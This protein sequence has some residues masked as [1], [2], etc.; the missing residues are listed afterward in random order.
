MVRGVSV[1]VTAALLLLAGTAG[2][3][4]IVFSNG[5]PNPNL[6]IVNGLDIQ[7]TGASSDDFLLAG[8]TLIDGVGFYFQNYYGID[9]WNLDINYSIFDDAGDVPGLLLDSGIGQNVVATDTGQPWYAFGN[10]FEVTFD[11]QNPFTATGGSRYWLQLGGATTDPAFPDLPPPNAFWVTAPDNGSPTLYPGLDFQ[12][13]PQPTE[14]QLAFNLTGTSIADVPE[15]ASLTLV[16][17][18]LL[19][20]ARRWRQKRRKNAP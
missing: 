18:G 14:N 1:V 11:L 5:G 9:G 7:G 6:D 3:S 19:L 17:L 10:V 12:A 15:P 2:A 16:G 13:D 20:G 4:P 8:N